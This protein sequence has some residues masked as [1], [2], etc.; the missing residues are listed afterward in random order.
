MKTATT[1]ILISAMFCFSVL[2]GSASFAADDPK[3]I[4]IGPLY[5]GMNIDEAQKIM[6]AKA[7][8][9]D[10]VFKSGKGYHLNLGMSGQMQANANK[11][12]IL[13]VVMD[14]LVEQ[15]F[16]Y[17]KA[18]L[19]TFAEKFRKANNIPEMKPYQSGL[20]YVNA[21]GNYTVEI[22]KYKVVAVYNSDIGD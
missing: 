10:K 5:L 7:G 3:A 19:K 13:I 17:H 11:E 16:E 12:V 1:Y 6:S 18:D 22:D 4:K 15:F 9:K 8:V 20:K 21:P 14:E 2:A